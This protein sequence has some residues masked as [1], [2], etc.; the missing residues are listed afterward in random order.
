VDLGIAGR[1][2]LVCA[3]S[4]G[5]GKGC[6]LALAGEGVHVTMNGRTAQTLE[7]AAEEARALG[8]GEV[9]TVC[10]DITSEEG[11]AQA[12]EVAGPID[13]LVNN[14]GGPPPGDF[15]DW[16]REQ[17]L[18]ALNANMLTPIELIKV[19]ID[20][21]G[22]RGFGRIVN[23][24]SSSVKSPI[25]TLGLSNG[26]RAGLTGFVAG[27]ARQMASKGVTING[28]LPGPFDT[29]RLRGG[30]RYTAEQAGRDF[31]QEFE[32]RKKAN[33]AGRF[34]SAE[35]FGA[36]CAFLCSA[37]AGYINGQNI[38]IDGGSYPGTL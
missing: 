16:G 31:E 37:H 14:A 36:L 19:T 33:P 28:I 1:R 27:V 24:T 5:L 11:R 7:A 9:R 25:P 23:I 13:I 6:A 8:A 38:V 34:G 2:A 22:E 21:M 18:S 17:W 30:I 35:E 3:S 29:D 4:K 32:T 12:L 15:R 20:G 10:C 26:A